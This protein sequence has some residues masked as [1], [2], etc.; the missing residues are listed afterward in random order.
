MPFRGQWITKKLKQKA[1]FNHKKSEGN[2]LVTEKPYSIAV[3][4][5]Q[6]VNH[7][8]HIPMFG[9][10]TKRWGLAKIILAILFLGKTIFQV[11]VDFQFTITGEI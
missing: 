6:N 2:R 3:N 11:I 10:L 1:E 8:L 9:H 4:T 5:L 7:D